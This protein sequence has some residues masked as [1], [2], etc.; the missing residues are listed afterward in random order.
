M[1]FAGSFLHLCCFWLCYSESFCIKHFT[2]ASLGRSTKVRLLCQN[3]HVYLILPNIA[4]FS[5]GMYFSLALFKLGMYFFFFGTI[6]TRVLL[7][8][9]IFTTVIVE[10]WDFT[11]ICIWSHF[12]IDEIVHPFFIL[13]SYLP[14]FW[15]VCWASW[16]SLAPFSV[17]YWCFSSQI[18]GTLLLFIYLWGGWHREWFILTAKQ[19]MRPTV[20]WQQ[21]WPLAMEQPW[22]IISGGSWFLSGAGSLRPTGS[23]SSV[24][25]ASP[26]LG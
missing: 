26:G 13:E 16:G 7:E 21:R 23:R 9:Q 10:K 2:F 5:L 15:A 20:W 19:R 6:Q 4:K 11:V 12:I 8:F 24:A 25:G 22:G 18:L 1:P 3:V 17:S 14:L